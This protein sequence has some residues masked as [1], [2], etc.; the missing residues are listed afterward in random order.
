MH[1]HTLPYLPTYLPTVVS[2]L[3]RGKGRGGGGIAIS[4]SRSVAKRC[5]EKSWQTC[6]RSRF[7]AC[8]DAKQ[9]RRTERDDILTCLRRT[10]LSRDS[11]RHV[12]RARFSRLR[13][14]SRAAKVYSQWSIE[15]LKKYIERCPRDP[16][17]KFAKRRVFAKRSYLKESK[18]EHGYFTRY[19]ES[20]DIIKSQ[21]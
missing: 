6:P 16:L 21:I 2:L 12:T 13:K 10:W 9:G 4:W 14:S 19:S 5:N 18:I 8:V 15:R 20:N 17:S 7:F 11:T 3:K 1:T